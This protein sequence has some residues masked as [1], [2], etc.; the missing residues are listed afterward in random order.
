ML[1]IDILYY[2]SLILLVALF[3]DVCKYL[4]LAYILFFQIMFFT[5]S[6]NVSHLFICIVYCIV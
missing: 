6:T 4:V 2:N 5:V 1:V 3:L